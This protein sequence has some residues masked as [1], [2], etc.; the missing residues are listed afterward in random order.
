MNVKVKRNQG[1]ALTTR[2]DT[3][4][5]LVEH[6]PLR[7]LSDLFNP[8]RLT[9]FFGKEGYMGGA[10][11]CEHV[12]TS[13]ITRGAMIRARACVA[14]EGVPCPQPFG[15]DQ[16]LPHGFEKLSLC[17]NLSRLYRV[18]ARKVRQH[19]SQTV[20][21]HLLTHDISPHPHGVASH[22]R[23]ELSM[24]ASTFT[25]PASIGQS[26]CDLPGS[27]LPAQDCSMTCETRPFLDMN[28][29]LQCNGILPTCSDVD[30]GPM[31]SVTR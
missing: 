20:R 28:H 14:Q 11:I 3:N 12:Q 8:L 27:A 10:T 4:G 26:C 25:R 19:E 21:H 1:S 29:S 2:H 16:A 7:H 22:T 15:E 17:R 13:K 18:S 6:S 31:T 30:L 9:C 24:P 5:R 23:V